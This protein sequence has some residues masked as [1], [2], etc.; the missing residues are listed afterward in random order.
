MSDLL[1]IK[2]LIRDFIAENISDEF[3]AVYWEAEKYKIPQKPYCML[4]ELSDSP[5]N[6]TAEYSDKQINNDRD[7]TVQ[8]HKQCVITVGVYVDGLSDYKVRKEFAYSEINKIRTLFERKD[9]R[10][11]FI[12][13]F[14]INSISGIR[15]LNKTVDGG[16]E[17][18]YE[19]DLTIG[20]NEIAS[21]TL[22][23]GQGVNVDITSPSG[24]DNINFEVTVDDDVEVEIK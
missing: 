6:R 20:Y 10:L 24:K 21:Y 7:K 18:R 17:Y 16:Y 22:P 2:P 4:T 15:E 9:T 3:N 14:S 5:T 13:H 12:R 23:I 19:I 1:S 8:M 11:F